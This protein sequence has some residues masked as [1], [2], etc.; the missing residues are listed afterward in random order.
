VKI[1]VAI[2]VYDGKLPVQGVKCLL[3][4]Q[5]IAAGLGDE[6]LVRFL[7]SCS[8]AAM[9]RNQLAQDFMDSDADRLVFLDADVTFAPG[10]IVKIAHYP[11]DFV[12]GAYRYKFDTENYPIGWLDKPELWANEHGL[13]EVQTLPGGFLSLSKKVFETLRAAHPE[14]EYEHFGKKAFCYFQMLFKD[15]SLYGEDSFFCKEWRDLGG[16]V[17]LDPE[18]TL[19]H[20]DANRPFVGHIGN[21]LKS[22]SGVK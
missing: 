5:T 12:G 18:L 9:G 14:R 13:L 8:H 21:W 6:L 22:R 7:P 16:Q 3:E 1:L 10:S 17:F 15:G 19:T 4:E 20:W 11:V 2:P